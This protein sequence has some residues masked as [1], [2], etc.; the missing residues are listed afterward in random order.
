MDERGWALAYELRICN[1]CLQNQS[2]CKKTST[3]VQFCERVHSDL[4]VADF[5]LVA[6]YSA[7]YSLLDKFFFYFSGWNDIAY[8]F[9]VCGDGRIYEG[10]GWNITGSQTLR[11]NAISLGICFIGT[12]FHELPH[13]VALTAGQNLIECGKDK[14]CAKSR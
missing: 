10:R 7:M 11:F 2:V 13:P 5:C 14:V 3:R 1:T 4:Q 9:L 12:F 6:L 8:N